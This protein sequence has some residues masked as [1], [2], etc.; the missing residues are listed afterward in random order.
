[1]V[2]GFAPI[3]GAGGQ[4]EAFKKR[5]LFVRHQVS[6]QAG[7]RRRYQLESRSTHDGNPFCQHGLVTAEY[8]TPLV[9]KAIVRHCTLMLCLTKRKLV[10]R[11]RLSWSDCHSSRLTR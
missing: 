1:M 7:L 6:C 8:Q 9:D 3:R 4:N 5:P 11:G 10:S 2:G